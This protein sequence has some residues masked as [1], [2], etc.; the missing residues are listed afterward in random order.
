M[1]EFYFILFFL[2]I[3]VQRGE[4]RLSL[5]SDSFPKTHIWPKMFTFQFLDSVVFISFTLYGGELCLTLCNPTHRSLPRLLCP[6]NFPDKNTEVGCHFLL[7]GV[8]PIQGSNLGILHCRRFPALQVDFSPTELAGTFTAL[9][10]V[11]FGKCNR[12]WGLINI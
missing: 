1:I 12:T 10:P 2:E 8:F 9:Q 5:R 3:L 4:T 6:W 7:Q 11:H